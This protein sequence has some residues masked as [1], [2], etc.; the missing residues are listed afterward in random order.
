MSVI[1]HKLDAKEIAGGKGKAEGANRAEAK[2]LEDASAAAAT[3]EGAEAVPLSKKEA[4]KQAKKAEK[5]ATKAGAPAEESKEEEAAAVKGKPVKPAGE[6]L[7]KIYNWRLG[8]IWVD[9]P[10]ITANLAKIEYEEVFNSPEVMQS[11]EWRSKSLTGKTPT[12]ETPDG[13][14]L[15]E[16]SAIARYLAEI[17]QGKLA[18]A[19]P[20]E[21]A[22]INQWIDYS[23]TTIQPHLYTLIRAVFGH[24]EPV[25]SDAFNNSLKEI[26][27]VLRHINGYL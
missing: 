24:G 22:Q 6:K 19:N 11:K 18:G 26:K 3:A 25:D 5:K 7:I 16:S 8:N 21:T 10:C 9:L 15:N 20:L 12:L 2:K 17:G 4:K 1:S 23:H 13:I 14:M 27:D